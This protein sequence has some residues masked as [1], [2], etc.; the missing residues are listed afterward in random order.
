M[1][2]ETFVMIWFALIALATGIVTGVAVAGT[3]LGT[4]A[5]ILSYAMLIILYG[6]LALGAYWQWKEGREERGRN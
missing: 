4:L 2:E 6:M 3:F 1:D 5:L